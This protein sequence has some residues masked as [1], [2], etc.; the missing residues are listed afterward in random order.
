[1]WTSVPTSICQAVWLWEPT[2]EGVC[3]ARTVCLEAH[4]RA[5]GVCVLHLYVYLCVSE[6]GYLRN[7]L[8]ALEGYCPECVFVHKRVHSCT[9]VCLPRN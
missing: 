1:M 3:P 9:H 5:C 8:R 6:V 2:C 7:C 4:M